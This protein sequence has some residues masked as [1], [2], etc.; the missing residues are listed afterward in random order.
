MKMAE[1]VLMDGTI[2]QITRAESV[3]LA[4]D[5]FARR[6][7]VYSFL[8]KKMPDRFRG[9]ADSATGAIKTDGYHVAWESLSEN[10]TTYRLASR[11]LDKPSHIFL[12]RNGDAY[13]RVS[14]T[15][16]SF[17][18]ITIIAFENKAP[19][20]RHSPGAL[21][22]PWQCNETEFDDGWHPLRCHDPARIPQT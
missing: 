7:A 21:I 4:N 15:R 22:Y 8:H 20:G 2:I 1:K 5:Y 16:D 17:P 6:R 9:D 14:A 3:A 11:L 18:M 10:K 19:Y 13:M 12:I